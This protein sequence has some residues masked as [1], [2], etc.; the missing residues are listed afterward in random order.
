MDKLA[1]LLFVHFTPD[2]KTAGWIKN[3]DTF[4]ILKSS[5]LGVKM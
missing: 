5:A 2:N 1:S 3:G 4:S